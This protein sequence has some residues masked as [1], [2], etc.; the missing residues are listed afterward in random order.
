MLGSRFRLLRHLR[1]RHPEGD[2]ACGVTSETLPR[3]V[4]CITV[5]VCERETDG[6]CVPVPVLRPEEDYSTPGRDELRFSRVDSPN[7]SFDVR[8]EQGRR[9]ELAIIVYDGDGMAYARGRV[10]NVTGVLVQGERHR[11]AA[12]RRVPQHR[13]RRPQRGQREGQD[14]AEGRRID[15]HRRGRQPAPGDD[16]GQQA[17]EGVADHGRPPGEPADD[18]ARTVGH[19]AD[20]LAGEQLG[21]RPG[22]LDRLRVVGPRDGDRRSSRPRGTSPPSGSSC[23]AAARGRG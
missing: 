1:P 13:E 12:V 17:A 11:P 15:G 3:E 16:L 21:I 5:T 18:V 6:D 9:Y 8:F 23:S 7:I 10:E 2:S 19:L 22:L 4:E 20:R 14:A